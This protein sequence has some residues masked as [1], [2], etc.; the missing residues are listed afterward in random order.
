MMIST[1]FTPLFQVIKHLN[2]GLFEVV[3]KNAVHQLVEPRS[4]FVI[5]Q[6]VIIDSEDFMD[7]QM[8]HG[9]FAFQRFLL[10]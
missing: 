10:Q 5:H 7:K 9:A 4:V 3:L 6:A 1:Y 2:E 8:Y